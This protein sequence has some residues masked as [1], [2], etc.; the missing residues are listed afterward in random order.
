M[1]DSRQREA[2]QRIQQ[3]LLVLLADALRVLEENHIPYSLICGTLLGAVR[4][5]GF[6]P[7][8][9]DVDLVLT[10]ESYQRFAAVYPAQCSPG[11]F[12]DVGD[13]WVPR[14]RRQEGGQLAFVDLFILDPLPQGRWARLWKLGRLKALQGMLKED[15]EYSRF[16]L[17]QRLLLRATALLGKPFAKDKKLRWYQQ[18]ARTGAPGSPTLHMANSAFALLGMA[19]TPQAFEDPVLV[20]FQGLQAR[21]PRD[22]AHILTKLYGPD[23]MVPPPEDQRVPQHIHL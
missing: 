9:D 15:T 8:D 10:R 6:I 20:P 19:F 3:E 11:F 5:Q 4:H 7:W 12:L 1:M 13:T 18:V 17:G 22:S 16:S 14:V 23:Y 21:I 2:L